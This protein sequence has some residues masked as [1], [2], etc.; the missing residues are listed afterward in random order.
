MKSD[1]E[2]DEYSDEPLSDDEEEVRLFIQREMTIHDSKSDKYTNKNIIKSSQT[3]SIPAEKSEI[4]GTAN[5][6]S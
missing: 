5:D 2:N 6:E 3:G 4:Y 1:D